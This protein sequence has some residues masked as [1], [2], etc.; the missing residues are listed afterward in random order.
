LL[1][2]ESC[3]ADEYRHRIGVDRVVARDS[4]DPSAVR[5]H[6][7]FALPRYAEA[8]AF[9]RPNSAQVADSGDAMASERYGDFPPVTLCTQFLGDV[10]VLPDGILDIRQSFLLGQ[11]LGCATRQARDPNAVALFGFLQ[12]NEIVRFHEAVLVEAAG[13][14]PASEKACNEQPTCVSGSV[15]SAATSEPA[16][17]ATA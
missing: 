10:Q 9:Q 14:E 11:A 13:V 16:R 1:G 8:R 4:D 2:G 15:I 12:R 3:G 5:H 6:D 17:A 7:V